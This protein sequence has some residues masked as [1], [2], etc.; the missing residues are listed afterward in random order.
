MNIFNLDLST[1]DLWLLSGVAACLTWLVPHRL[2]LSREI[3]SARRS[4]GIRFRSSILE[5]M[6]G[7]YPAP[8]SWP[9]EKLNIIKELEGRFPTLQTAVADFSPHL[10][11]HKKWLL[12]RAWKIYRLGPGGRAVDGQY[13]WQY[14]PHTGEGYAGGKHYKHDNRATYQVSFKKNV[15]RL[16]SFASEA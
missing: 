10:P 8:T 7:L 3:R 16:L 9:K 14:V 5:A 1:T 4:A 15:E 2:S 12:Q 13:Y 6:S 11:P